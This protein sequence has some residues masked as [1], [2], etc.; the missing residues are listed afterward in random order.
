MSLNFPNFLTSPALF[1]RADG[2][3]V[4]LPIRALLPGQPVVVLAREVC[5][6]A[7]FRAPRGLSRTAQ[8][9]AARL[10]A[11]MVNP[12]AETGSL[13]TRAGDQFGVWW[14]NGDWVRER[15]ASF[16]AS[17]RIVPETM[18]RPSGRGWRVVNASSGVEAQLWR[19]DFLV[20]DVWSR[21]AFDEQEWEYVIRAFG[22]PDD[23]PATRPPVETLPFSLDSP[24]LKT[25]LSDLTLERALP[26][27]IAAFVTLILCMTGFWLGQGLHLDSETAKIN[28][29]TSQIRTTSYAERQHLLGELSQLQDIRAATSQRD[30]LAVLLGAERTLKPF[31]MQ[32]LGF[33][34]TGDKLAITLPNEAGAGLDLISDQ[35]QESG[36][37]YDF[38]PRRDASK[39]TF[40][41]RV[42][43]RPG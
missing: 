39:V 6:F 1:L 10:Q 40:E 38:K 3:L 29:Q 9:R 5:G 41:M 19:D 14:W 12:Y 34:A 37:F 42:R 31:G 33:S 18:A 20:G 13:I 43:P 23:A 4:E 16:G 15:L 24:Y 25:R 36:E 22:S 21:R 26:N 11:G 28:R 8:L 27:A 7:Y 35:L 30:P 2:E 17:A 32:I